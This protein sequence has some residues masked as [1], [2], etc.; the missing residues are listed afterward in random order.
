MHHTILSICV[1]LSFFFPTFQ[2]SHHY[3]SVSVNS[4]NDFSRIIKLMFSAPCHVS[5]LFFQISSP[6]LLLNFV[7]VILSVLLFLLSLSL[8][9][10]F[11]ICQQPLHAEV[12]GSSSSFLS[13]SSSSS[14]S[15]S[16][17]SS[18]APPT[19]PSFIRFLFG[20]VYLLFSFL[21]FSSFSFSSPLPTP[22][23]S[24]SPH[25]VIFPPP[26]LPPPPPSLLSNHL[27]FLTHTHTLFFLI[28]VSTSPSLPPLSNLDEPRPIIA[29][30]GG[31]LNR[32]QSESPVTEGLLFL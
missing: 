7:S 2:R 14:S 8:L 12:G 21:F 20:N 5:L 10:L 19:P 16:F 13:S 4:H 26:P 18:T 31:R 25:P 1:L 30:A 23:P 22:S 27:N 28:L 15:F 24:P 29:R 6:L 3:R 32:C 17:S 11:C 9:L